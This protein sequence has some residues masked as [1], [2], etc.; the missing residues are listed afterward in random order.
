MPLGIV[1]PN[2][3][4]DGPAFGLKDMDGYV[5]F[6]TTHAEHMAVTD[7]EYQLFG[8][9]P[10]CPAPIDLRDMVTDRIRR[11]AVNMKSQEGI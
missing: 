1:L 5:D 9:V 7:I 11:G 4:K 2:H 6:D 8:I 3:E 10:W